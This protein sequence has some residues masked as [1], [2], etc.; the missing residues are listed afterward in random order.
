VA[1]AFPDDGLS[2]E[3]SERTLLAC[4]LRRPTGNQTQA[5][6]LL[7]TTR[8]TLRCKIKKFNLR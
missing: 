1:A 5:G 8:D 7:R 3:D 6:R 4:P 2:L